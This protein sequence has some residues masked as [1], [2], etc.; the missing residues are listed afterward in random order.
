MKIDKRLLK[1]WCCGDTGS[2]SEAIVFV[3]CGL[4]PKAILKTHWSSYP[5][6]SGDFGRC[7]KLL[8]AIPEWRGRIKEMACLG[9]VW[10]KIAITWQDLENLYVDE[11]PKELY[12]K[13]SKLRKNDENCNTADLGNG[14]SISVK[15]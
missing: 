2:S 11:K 13:L 14:V 5:Y 8:Q 7:Y 15:I 4:N 10:D 1:W 12:S 6:D 3:M 9:N